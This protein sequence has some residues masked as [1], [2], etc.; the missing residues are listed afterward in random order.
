MVIIVAKTNEEIERAFAW[1]SENEAKLRENSQRA[2]ISAGTKRQMKQ[3]TKAFLSAKD[4]IK[5]GHTIVGYDAEKIYY[6]G[7]LPDVPGTYFFMDK[8]GNLLYVGSTK[9]LSQRIPQSFSERN[10]KDTVC[11][12]RYRIANSVEE[13]R[14]LESVA[15]NIFKPKLN[16]IIPP[17]PKMDIHLENMT[18]FASVVEIRSVGK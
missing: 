13:A 5:K 8:D 10:G 4:E 14:D 15:I 16:T 7:K 6:V 12:I 2:I 17:M 1:L 18:G 3:P 11:E 9:N